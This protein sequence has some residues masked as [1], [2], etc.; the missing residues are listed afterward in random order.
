MNDS[1]IV[2]ELESNHPTLAACIQV[3]STLAASPL[4]LNKRGRLPPLSQPHSKLRIKTIV[5]HAKTWHLAK[6]KLRLLSGFAFGLP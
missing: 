2:L 3:Q 5:F 4:S 6:K 1:G